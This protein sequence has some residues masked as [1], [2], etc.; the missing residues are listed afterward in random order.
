MISTKGLGDTPTIQVLDVSSN[1]LPSLEELDK[2]C[3]LLSLNVSCNNILTVSTRK[4]YLICLTLQMM[5]AVFQ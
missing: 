2:L 5:K 4:F 3:L 1:H